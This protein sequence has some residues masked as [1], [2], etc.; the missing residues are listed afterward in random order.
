MY[1]D[2]DMFDDLFIYIDKCACEISNSG[3]ESE[4]SGRDEGELHL[5]S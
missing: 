1:G 2:I 3:R 4:G 5:L